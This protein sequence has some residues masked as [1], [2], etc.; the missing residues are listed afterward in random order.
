MAYIEQPPTPSDEWRMP[1]SR[2]EIVTE[3]DLCGV[4]LD[5]DPTQA[6]TLLEL[7]GTWVS[8]VRVADALRYRRA[9]LVSTVTSPDSLDR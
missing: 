6:R 5:A 2:A 8:R 9:R 7:S 1:R 3:L 4:P